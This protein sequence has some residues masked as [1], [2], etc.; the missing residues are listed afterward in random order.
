[1]LHTHTLSLSLS[2]CRQCPLTEPHWSGPSKVPVL[3]VVLISVISGVLLVGGAIAL[4]LWY[5]RG[6]LRL[7]VHSYEPLFSGVQHSASHSGVDPDDD[8]LDM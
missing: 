1:M 7:R 8:L 5:R 2:L 4:A 3:P 6:M